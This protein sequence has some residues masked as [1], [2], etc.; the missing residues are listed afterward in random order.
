MGNARLRKIETELHETTEFAERIFKKTMST[1]VY[2]DSLPGIDNIETQSQAEFSFFQP[3]RDFQPWFYIG[4]LGAMVIL[5]V[6]LFVQVM[7]LIRERNEIEAQIMNLEEVVVKKEEKSNS[8]NRL[9][10]RPPHPRDYDHKIVLS[11]A[12]L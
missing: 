9:I 3:G 2:P 10:I 7:K 6:A 12:P 11:R 5:F 4:L 1:T 8:R